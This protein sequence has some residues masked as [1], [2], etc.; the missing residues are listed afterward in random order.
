MLD[1]PCRV[2]QQCVMI[3]VLLRHLVVAA[4]LLTSGERVHE[5]LLGH[6]GGSGR[7]RRC[8]GGGAA[9]GDAARRAGHAGLARLGL[10]GLADL[11]VALGELEAD[12]LGEVGVEADPLLQSERM[13]GVGEESGKWV[14]F[15]R[16]GIAW[17]VLQMFPLTVTPS[18]PAQSVAV[19]RLSQ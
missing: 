12:R 14:V 18:G 17:A 3:S 1:K 16:I 5:R 19:T 7:G 6:G 15:N 10:L 4:T 8:G 13:L 11:G 9:D 2:V